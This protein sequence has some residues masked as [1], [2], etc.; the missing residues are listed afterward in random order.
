MAIV[1]RIADLLTPCPFAQFLE[2]FWARK[3]LY[4]H[5]ECQEFFNYLGIEND[6][7]RVFEVESL[8][9]PTVR[10]YRKGQLVPGE[11]FSRS[12][13]AGRFSFLDLIN[14]ERVF[15]N[16]TSGA[17]VSLLGVEQYS[18]PVDMLARSLERIFGGKVSA[19]AWLSPP[20]ADHLPARSDATDGIV[21]QL[22]G[23][24]RWT[25]WAG[26]VRAAT[27]ANVTEGPRTLDNE[28]EYPPIVDCEVKQGDTLY[29]PREFVHRVSAT[30]TPSIHLVFNVHT[31]TWNVLV[32][33]LVTDII[34]ELERDVEFRNSIRQVK[35]IRRCEHRDILLQMAEKFA[36]SMTIDRAYA[37]LREKLCMETQRARKGG[38]THAHA[39]TGIG[40]DTSLRVRDI[41]VSLRPDHNNFR[42]SFLGKALLLPEQVLP[43]LAMI[44]SERA[45]TPNMLPGLDDEE[46]SLA[47]SRRLFLEGLLIKND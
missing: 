12:W 30:D 46:S 33:A 14:M 13:T 7:Q 16:L 29:V 32:D 17:T 40:V 22:I 23:A 36:D 10:F 8:R 4:I 39:D 27:A 28:P 19:N 37:A 25:V 21:L 38:L 35:S 24:K 5:R 3:P 47:L 1:Y 34:E 44:L 31:P 41:I 15:S 45:F 6:L 18:E 2:T 43:A 42:L 26:D 11:Q 20:Y 9:Y